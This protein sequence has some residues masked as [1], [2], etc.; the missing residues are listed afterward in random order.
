MKKSVIMFLV[1]VL[2]GAGLGWYYQQ[3]TTPP[4]MQYASEIAT[5]GSIE[6]QVLATG[7]VQAMDMVEVGSQV[8]GQVNFLGVALGQT[9]KKGELIAKIDNTAQQ[10]ALKEEELNFQSLVTQHNIKK[11]SLAHLQD[12]YDNQKQAYEGKVLAHQELVKTANQLALTKQE[13]KLSELSLAQAKLKI[14]TAKDNLDYTNIKAPIDGTV[15]AVVTKQGQTINASSSSPTIVKIAQMDTVQIKVKFSESDMPKLKVGMN[16]Y[17]SPAGKPDDKRQTTLDSLELSP[18]SESGAVY[19]AGTLTVP[20][21]NHELLIGMSANV[22]I[23]T[24]KADET[25]LIPSTALGEPLQTGEYQV[26][27]LPK[28]DNT[29]MPVT[30][31][32]KTIKIGLK[33]ATHAQ[34]LSGLSVGD[35]VVVVASD[36]V[37]DELDEF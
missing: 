6:T 22:V 1:I 26:Q 13:L 30:P 17:F 11:V 15:V 7:T 10:N 12:E 37:V 2:I 21:P 20:N 33:N 8:T 35:E 18:I 34:V 24:D 32:T 28:L 19:Y 5:L 23:I 36:G 9:V 25:L 4:P 14:A 29:N 27:V 31:I 16:A 3:S